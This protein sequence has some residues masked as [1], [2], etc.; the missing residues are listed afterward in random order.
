MPLVSGS[1]KKVMSE[2]ISK[3]VKEGYPHRQAIAI[4]TEHAR[5]HRAGSSSRIGA[6]GKN[7]ETR[8]RKKAKKDY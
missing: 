6:E 8:R 1:S 2:N 3:L 5:K 4:A 7:T